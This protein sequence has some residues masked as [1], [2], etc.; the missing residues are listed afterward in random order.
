DEFLDRFASF[1]L[2]RDV[3]IDFI[4]RHAYTSGPSQ[5]VPFGVYQ[6]LRPASDLLA[7]FA[8]PR[9]QLAGTRLAE[10]PAH[11]TEFNS[12]Y[13]PD[14][15]IHD[16]AFQA[17][18]LAP[19]LASGGDLVDSFAYWTFSDVFE[20]VGI[21]TALFHGGFGLLTHRQIPKPVY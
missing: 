3:P 7:Q 6:T 15:P 11:I 13:R 18:Y 5:H 1:V 4:S 21:P 19:V 20:E 10:L 17:A 2:E 12:S 14:N 16:T 9:Q 8:R